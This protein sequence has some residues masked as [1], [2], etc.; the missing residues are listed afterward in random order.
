MFCVACC[1]ARFRM[2][3][4]N[5]RLSSARIKNVKQTRHHKF[6]C[7]AS[8]KSHRGDKSLHLSST[9]ESAVLDWI[10]KVTACIAATQKSDYLTRYLASAISSLQAIHN[11][12]RHKFSG[13][14][15]MKQQ[16]HKWHFKQACVIPRCVHVQEYTIKLTIFNNATKAKAQPAGITNTFVHMIS[17]KKSRP[18]QA[19]DTMRQ[20]ICNY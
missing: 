16:L 13:D 4:S 5:S 20:F 1:S 10:T 11:C 14:I 9:A 3:D 15:A 7:H 8:Y 6:V 19:Q 18:L 2:Y 12:I 17:R